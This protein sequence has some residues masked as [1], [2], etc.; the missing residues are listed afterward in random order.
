MTRQLSAQEQA[1]LTA[2]ELAGCVYR[3]VFDETKAAA[4]RYEQAAKIG[5]PLVLILGVAVGYALGRR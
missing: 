5:I 2:C 1:Q 4:D 3:P